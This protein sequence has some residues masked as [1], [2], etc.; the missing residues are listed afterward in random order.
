MPQGKYLPEGMLLETERNRRTLADRE[1]L[2]QAMKEGTIVEAL[3]S[4]SGADRGLMVDLNGLE[5]FISREETAVGIVSGRTREV[6]VMTR[7]GR[8]V[9]FKIIGEIE[10]GFTLSR[11]AAQREATEYFMHHLCPGDIMRCSV[12][13]LERFGAFV[14]MGCGLPSLIGLENISAS[15]I[16]HPRERFYPGQYIRAA[17]SE[18]DRDDARVTL[19]HKELLGTWEQNASRFEPGQTIVGVVRGVEEYG[20]FVELTPNLTGLAEPRDG[21]IPGDCVSVFIKSILPDRMKI[22]LTV[23]DKLARRGPGYISDA[24]YLFEGNRIGRWQ[25]SPTCCKVKSIYTDFI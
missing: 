23:I 8:P 24:D 21:L 12:T 15:R 14:D 10:R 9:C 25:Y 2:R 5:G 7:V 19:T 18:I 13:R 3:A 4:S 17:V 6:A 22:K 1:G 16:H 11:R 20:I